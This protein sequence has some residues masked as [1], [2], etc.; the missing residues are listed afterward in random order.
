MSIR[1]ALRENPFVLG[2]MAGFTDMTF[3]RLCK[4]NDCSI[5]F[6][7]MVSAKGLYYNDK[8]TE[9]LLKIHEDEKPVGLQIFGSDPEIMAWA[10]DKL[11]DRENEYLDINMGCPVPKVVKNGDGSALMKKPELVKEIV[12]SVVKASKKPVTV[13]IRAGWDAQS[14]NAVEIAKIIEASGA[15][16]VTV[17]GRTREQFYEGKADWNSIK[18]VKD[19]VSIPVIG[20][21]DV[22]SAQDGIAM[23]EQ[24]GCD[25]VMIARG[26]R[27]NPWIFRELFHYYKTGEMLER[28]NIDEIIDMI[29]LHLEMIVK[30]KGEYIA[31]REMR[32]HIGMYIKGVYKNSETKCKV[33]EQTEAQDVVRVLNEYR[34][35]VKAK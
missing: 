23:M 17:H 11:N 12:T 25:G 35:I 30:E 15:V 4:Q 5:V 31:V 14:K 13:K 24:T 1:E 6:S 2:P 16:A 32:K 21:G 9:E 28:P 8:K 33:N 3:R 29:L 20:S 26:A 27:G 19:N 7:E 18:E 34:E 10:A 22:M